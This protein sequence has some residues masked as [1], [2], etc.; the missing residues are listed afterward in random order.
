MTDNSG[1]E[2]SVRSSASSAKSAGRGPPAD[3]F[4]TKLKDA[5]K[6]GLQ[7]EKEETGDKSKAN[8][9]DL[10]KIKRE[11]QMLI[12]DEKDNSYGD[13]KKRQSGTDRDSS[14]KRKISTYIVKKRID[15]RTR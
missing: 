5:E 7:Q 4:D 13:G 9:G 6:G 14:L 3:S 1:D 15:Q 12:N 11:P 2:V 8:G 10:G